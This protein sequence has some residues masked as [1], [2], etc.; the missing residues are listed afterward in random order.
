MTP[1]QKMEL[2]IQTALQTIGANPTLQQGSLKSGYLY[3]AYVSTLVTDVALN[4]G[5]SVGIQNPVNGPFQFP[6]APRELY[7]SAPSYYELSS[8]K[9]T[10]EL[11]LC[12]RCDGVSGFDHE[13]DILI[14]DEQCA[15]NCRSQ[16]TR[17][18]ANDVLFLAECK[19]SGKVEYSIGREFIGVC[20]EFPIPPFRWR[21]D[22]GLGALVGTLNNP[23]RSQRAFDLVNARKKLIG[24]SF[25]EPNH[26]PKVQNFQNRVQ[27]VLQPQLV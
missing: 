15:R 20:F 23:N 2:A 17:P 9:G 11:Q 3:S 5:M 7:D 22:D 13:L 1:E 4:L 10:W 8:S 12:C 24:A 18:Q 26:S 14:L 25:V 27:A 21:G 6:T 19:N 16:S